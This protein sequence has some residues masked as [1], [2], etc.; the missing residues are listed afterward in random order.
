[1]LQAASAAVAEADVFASFAERAETLALNAPE[2]CGDS[3][4]SID[5]GRHLVIE[6]VHEA[7][8]VPNDLHL[9]DERRMLMITGPNMGGKST[10]MR[11]TALIVIRLQRELRT[12]REGEN[13]SVGSRLYAHRRG[14]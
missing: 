9:A 3:G 6:R 7:P 5:G 14:G 4:V 1:M 11:Q 13:W 10:Y 8:F 2:L 12:G